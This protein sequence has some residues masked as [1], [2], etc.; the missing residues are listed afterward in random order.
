VTQSVLLLQPSPAW[1]VSPGQQV[2]LAPPQSV[3]RRVLSSQAKGAEQKSPPLPRQQRWPAPPHDW[4]AS[5]LQTVN[6][7]VQPPP[8]QQPSP[9]WPQAPFWQPPAVQVP[10]P[11]LQ[12]PPAATQVGR[13]GAS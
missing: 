8:A 10:P 4:Q 7:C 6:A 5:L 11:L 12:V 1:Q 9:V 2:W 13:P 3:Q